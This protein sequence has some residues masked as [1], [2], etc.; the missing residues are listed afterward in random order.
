[1]GNELMDIL[2]DLTELNKLLQEIA[3]DMAEINAALETL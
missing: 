1:M 2:I 3:A